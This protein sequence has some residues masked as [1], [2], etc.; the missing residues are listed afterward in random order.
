MEVGVT[1]VRL[2][3]NST[4]C[5]RAAPSERRVA[6]KEKPEVRLQRERDH[7]KRRSGL[8]IIESIRSFRDAI[9]ASTLGTRFSSPLPPPD[10]TLFSQPSES[11]RPLRRHSSSA[12]ENSDRTG[13][14]A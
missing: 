14:D 12:R 8:E 10:G 9:V 11:C 7:P 13:P 6:I 2:P 4:L 1:T 3:R 5:S